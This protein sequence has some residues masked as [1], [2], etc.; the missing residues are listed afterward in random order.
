MTRALWI[1]AATLTAFWCG[2]EVT[3]AIDARYVPA[4]IV[5]DA[6]ETRGGIRD[7]KP[8]LSHPTIFQERRLAIWRL[9]PLSIHRR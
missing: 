9:E 4:P 7:G 3:A 6:V 5:I 8:K 2:Y 1:M